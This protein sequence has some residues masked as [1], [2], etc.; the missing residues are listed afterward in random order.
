M[1][2]LANA[3]AD[4][5]AGKKISSGDQAAL[6]SALVSA[7]N[8]AAGS[9]Q[10]AAAIQGVKDGLVIAGANDAAVATVAK[11]LMGLSTKAK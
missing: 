11:A 3:V 4:A 9:P 7:L 8:A 6:A 10:L 1:Q 2:A 5:F